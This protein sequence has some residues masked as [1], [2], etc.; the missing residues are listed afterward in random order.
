[1][2]DKLFRQHEAARKAAA[3][4]T[5]RYESSLKD[6]GTKISTDKD[7]KTERMRA[8]HTKRSSK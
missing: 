4:T 7:G 1:M 6:I 3:A 2:A 8:E 5:K